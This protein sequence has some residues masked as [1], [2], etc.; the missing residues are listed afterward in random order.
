MHVSPFQDTAGG[1]LGPEQEGKQASG[2][3]SRG[4][5]RQAGLRDGKMGR[6]EEAGTRP[7]HCHRE[8]TVLWPPHSLGLG[9]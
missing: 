8:Q 7:L 4:E 2:M 5:D 1:Y 9:T 3:L 6:A